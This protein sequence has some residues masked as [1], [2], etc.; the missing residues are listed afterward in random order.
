MSQL[1]TPAEGGSR[2]I[3][4][5]GMAVNHIDL[6]TQD[7]I[8][9]AVALADKAALAIKSHSESTSWKVGRFTGLPIGIYQNWLYEQNREW[10][11]TDGT[12]CVLWCVEFPD[13]RCDYADKRHYIAATRREYNAGRHQAD[14]PAVPSIA[15]Q[16]R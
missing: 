2:A 11:F 15:Y 5:A 7:R 13:A 10:R 8:R 6:E 3:Q 4:A 9:G 16:R 14:A 1:P 12:L